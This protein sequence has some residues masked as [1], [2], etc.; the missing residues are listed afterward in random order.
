MYLNVFHYHKSIMVPRTSLAGYG[1]VMQ[2][3]K[4]LFVFIRFHDVS[5]CCVLILSAL[6]A[7]M[8]NKNLLY[9]I[10]SH[11]ELSLLPW[12][13]QSKKNLIDQRVHNYQ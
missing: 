5:N 13:P 7:K 1:K 12:N 3:K 10:Y 2:H 11:S 8:Y 6:E 9:I 4:D